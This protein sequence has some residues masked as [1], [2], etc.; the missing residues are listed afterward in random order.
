MRPELVK[1]SRKLNRL[2]L[3][4]ANARDELR[5]AIADI[6]EL[7]DDCDEAVYLLERAADSLSKQV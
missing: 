4:V 5:D 7:G 6:D 2:M 1:L 3:K